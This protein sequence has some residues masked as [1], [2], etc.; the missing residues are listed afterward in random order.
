M[1]REARA[2]DIER[3]S[4]RPALAVGAGSRLNPISRVP[5]I[6]AESFIKTIRKK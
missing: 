3:G 6:A 5:L 4:S 1:C 2:R